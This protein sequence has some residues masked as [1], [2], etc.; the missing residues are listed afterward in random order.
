MSAK[1][2]PTFADKRCPAVSV[3]DPYGLI[4]GF[5]DL[6]YKIRRPDFFKGGI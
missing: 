5:L 1:F 6:L 4:L 2:V 3:T